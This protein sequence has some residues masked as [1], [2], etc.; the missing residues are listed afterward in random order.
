MCIQT[1][2]TH[3]LVKVTLM[4][5]WGS[6]LVTAGNL[7]FKQNA[8]MSVAMIYYYLHDVTLFKS[9]LGRYTDLIT[10]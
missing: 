4:E 9:Y 10:I 7:P 3:H 5:S 8:P 1:T 2:L 6:Y